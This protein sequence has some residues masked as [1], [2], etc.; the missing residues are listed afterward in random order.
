[1][2]VVNR[3]ERDGVAHQRAKRS[4]YAVHLVLAEH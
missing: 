4:V 2:R 1:M 3:L